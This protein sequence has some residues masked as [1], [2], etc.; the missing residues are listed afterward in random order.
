MVRQNALLAVHLRHLGT[1]HQVG[2]PPIGREMQWLGEGFSQNEGLG[3]I[4]SMLWTNVANAKLKFQSRRFYL[5]Y[6]ALAPG[7]FLVFFF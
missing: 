3:E 2:S 7:N 6:P 4:T 1:G 5:I